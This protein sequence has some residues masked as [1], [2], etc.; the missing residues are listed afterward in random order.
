[1]SPVGA[2]GRPSWLLSAAI[3]VGVVL[4]V[5][6]PH[7]DAVVSDAK[8]PQLFV[9]STEA[10]TQELQGATPAGAPPWPRPGWPRREL[11]RAQSSS[12]HPERTRAIPSAATPLAEL[13]TAH[14]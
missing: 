9:T 12:S 14:V 11:E 7:V 2:G 6:R 8:A 10:T 1:M 13:L 4:A 5:V 3:L